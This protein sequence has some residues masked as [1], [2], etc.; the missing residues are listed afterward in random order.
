MKAHLIKNISLTILQNIKI[1]LLLELVIKNN[2]LGNY[3]CL[4]DVS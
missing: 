3:F 2:Y 1:F 4:I